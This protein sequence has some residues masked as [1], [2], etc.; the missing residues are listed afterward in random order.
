MPFLGHLFGGQ[1]LTLNS[2][3]PTGCYFEVSIYP[4][5]LN[6]I[7]VRKIANILQTNLLDT[8]YKLHMNYLAITYKLP[9]NYLA[10]T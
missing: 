1:S 2:V 8:T 4:F 5:Y 3:P 6:A 7:K 10:I 9:S